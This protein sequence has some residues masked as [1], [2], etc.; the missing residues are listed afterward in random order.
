MAHEL[1]I[2]S[3][4]ASMFYV[5]TPPWHGLGTRLAAPPTSREAIE[6]ARLDWT[7]AKAPLYVVG[8]TRLHELPD[9]FALLRED[10]IG[11]PDCHIFGI[12]GREYVPLQNRHAFDFFDPLVQEGHASYVTAG[13]LGKGERVWIQ[14][15][16]TG[17]LEIASGDSVERFLLLSNSHDGT[18][19]VQVKLTPVRIVCN[20]T[21]I[22]ALSDGRAINIRHDQDMAGRLEQA[23]E[24]LGL[25]NQR[26]DEVARLFRRV[27]ATK[28]TREVA[29]RYFEV[30]FPN[31]TT[32]E[33]DRRVQESRRWA[34]HFY[35]HGRGTDLPEVKGTLWAAYNGVTEL[36]DHRKA[37][38]SGADTTLGRLNSVWFGRGA[39]IKERALRVAEQMVAATTRSNTIASEAVYDGRRTDVMLSPRPL[40]N[41]A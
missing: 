6:A 34:F 33:A 39:A 16:L 9:R 13:A 18:S 27:A 5:D 37:R 28:L 14:A 23:K 3:G 7:V 17:D 10:Q 21:L 29:L 8:G 40:A 1:L 20:N 11:H 2:E 41:T 22:L 35:E 30:V 12:A 15:R 38:P 36:I 25:V 26:Y 32:P 31:G 24:L 19:S 4:R